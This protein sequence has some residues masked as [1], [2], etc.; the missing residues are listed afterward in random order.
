MI[1]P[2]NYTDDEGPEQI[3]GFLGL[4]FDG[5]AAFEAA[6]APLKGFD[7]WTYAQ[8][9]DELEAVERCIVVDFGSG[10]T[11]LRF[12]ASS[13]EQIVAAI[14]AVDALYDC[15]DDQGPAGGAGHVLVI[16]LIGRARQL[17]TPR[18]NRKAAFQ[19]PAP[20]ATFTNERD[21]VPKLRHIMRKRVGPITS[22]GQEEP[23]ITP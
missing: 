14:P 13:V 15:P 22:E 12:D 10:A 8:L 2:D 1:E 6:L 23:E 3:P 4:I 19:K 16:L 17:G 9:A 21:K 11:E 18:V 5:N 20:P 7:F